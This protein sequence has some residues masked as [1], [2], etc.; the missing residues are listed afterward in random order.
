MPT[1]DLPPHDKTNVAVDFA[2]ARWVI[3]GLLLLVTAGFVA[4]RILSIPPPPLSPEVAHDPLLVEGRSVYLGRCAA[5]HG[6]EGRGDGPI[7]GHLMGPPVGNISD[8]EWK[9]GDKPHEVMAVISK[10]V[11]GTRMA[12]WGTVL[13]SSQLRA[14]T[15][16]VFH[17]AHQPVPEELRTTRP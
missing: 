7:A 14:V 8:G 12:G 16:Y 3:L 5:C 4:Y 11:D 9:H 6:L 2:A 17:L 15:A 1:D 10:G 13:E